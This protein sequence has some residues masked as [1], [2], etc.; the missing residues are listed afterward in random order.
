MGV[1][2]L[3]AFELPLPKL[4]FEFTYT[5]IGKEE[6]VWFFCVVVLGQKVGDGCYDTECC[7]LSMCERFADFPITLLLSFPELGFS[8]LVVFVYLCELHEEFIFGVTGFGQLFTE[9][10]DFVSQVANG[11]T[12]LCERFCARNKLFDFG[13]VGV[14]L[15]EFTPALKRLLV[16]TGSEGGKSF[17]EEC[18]SVRHDQICSANVEIGGGGK[19][20]EYVGRGTLAMIGFL[21]HLRK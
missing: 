6:C 8:F 3:C 11:L 4:I 9:V 19:R 17:F 14:L 10:Y 13:V 7:E 20:D 16:G 5:G 18:M 12:F 21:D 15:E 1:V 2:V